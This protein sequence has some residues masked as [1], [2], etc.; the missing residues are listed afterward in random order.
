MKDSIPESD[1]LPYTRLSIL[2]RSHLKI[3]F[4]RAKELIHNRFVLASSITTIFLGFP[5]ILLSTFFPL[6]GDDRGLTN[7]EIGLAVGT[8]GIIPTIFYIHLGKIAD[9]YGPY[10]PTIISLVTLGVS[11]FAIPYTSSLLAYIGLL[12]LSSI[13]WGIGMT[14]INKMLLMGVP[15]TDRGMALGTFGVFI[16]TGR[17]IAS[18][19]LGI[20]ASIFGL[21]VIFTI[22]A[23]MLFIGAIMFH[24]I[25]DNQIK[26]FNRSN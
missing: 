20:C 22:T 24:V 17:T 9:R 8:R 5:I 16:S 11:L 23:I 3:S 2:L 25:F 1:R 21:E 26:P 10:L 7:T 4:I 13:S 15:K 12:M 19:T 14:A 18:V 6:F